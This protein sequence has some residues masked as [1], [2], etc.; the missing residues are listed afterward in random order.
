VK[1]KSKTDFEESRVRWDA[2]WKNEN[3]HPLVH[4]VIPKEGVKPVDKPLY[5]AGH[6]GDF[7][8]VIEQ[9]YNWAD[10]H[11]FIGD[12]LPFYQVEFGPDHFSTFLGADMEYS[13]DSNTTSWAVPFVKDWGSAVLKF[14]KDSPWWER[15]VKFIRALRKDLDGMVLIAAPTLVAG[16]DCLAAIRGVQELLMDTVECPEKVKRALDMKCLAYEEIADE[17]FK[18]LGQKEIGSVNRHGL[19]SSGKLAIPQCDFSCMISPDMYDEFVAPFVEK[20]TE[21]LDASEYHLDGPGALVHLERIC[22]FKKLGIV[23]WVPGAG[24]AGL[25]DWTDLYKKLDT[26]GKGMIIHE[27]LEYYRKLLPQIKTRQLFL[28]TDAKDRKEAESILEELTSL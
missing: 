19:Y 27:T 25:K 22:S 3:K 7:S 5:M 17:L 12:A 2:F 9:V 18:E 10:T 20:E 21:Y 15:T 4:I 24:D 14:R 1:L 13:K 26:L 23:Q 16:M 11:E 28:K 6:N 8:P